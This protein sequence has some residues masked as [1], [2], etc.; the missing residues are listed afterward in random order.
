[1]PED[2]AVEIDKFLE[3]FISSPNKEWK[4]IFI[5]LWSKYFTIR[6]TPVSQNAVKM[7]LCANTPC[8]AQTSPLYPYVVVMPEI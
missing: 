3:A 6:V 7:L 2:V 8:K 1:M 4:G 5:Y